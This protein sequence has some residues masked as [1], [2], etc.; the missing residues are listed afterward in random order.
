MSSKFSKG[1]IQFGSEV[2]YLQ[3]IAASL[4]PQELAAK[5]QEYQRILKVIYETAQ[6]Q[7]LDL[8]PYYNALADIEANL[9]LIGDLTPKATVGE[10]VVLFIDG[11]NLS[12]MTRDWLRQDIDYQR[13]LIYFSRDC[14]LQAAY[15]YTA[16]ENEADAPSN[17][18]HYVLKKMG[19]RLV[20]KPLK[21]FPDGAKKGNLDI[22]LAL[23][24]LEWVGRADRVVLFSGDGD[25]APLLERMRQKG[26]KTQVV[27]YVVEGNNP[28]ASELISAADTFTNLADIINEFA[29]IKKQ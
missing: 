6:K 19:Y 21:I 28:T 5:L 29:R 9:K 12:I 24:M 3:G 20:T 11:A 17:T 16:V 8:L 27:S 18:F 26:A 25:F 2:R 1:L 14:S 23:D 13:L 15:Y 7:G 4:R 10:K 22:E